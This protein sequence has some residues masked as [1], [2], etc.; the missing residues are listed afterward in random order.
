MSLLTA[1]GLLPLASCAGDSA[2]GG[3]PFPCTDPQPLLSENSGYLVCANGVTV[4]QG[5]ANCP[6][7]LPRVEAQASDPSGACQYDADC[8]EGDHGYC[9]SAPPATTLGYCAYGCTTDSDCSQGMICA[10]AVPVG[11]CVPTT[12]S[13]NADCGS[14]LHCASHGTIDGCDSAFACQQR[15][16]ACAT[17]ADCGGM[18]CIFDEARGVRVCSGGGCGA[19]GRP[20]LVQGTARVATSVT[21][22]D[23]L[24]G[25]QKP[26]LDGL[27]PELRRLLA[28]EWTR[29]AELEHASIAAFSRFL[30]ELLA[31]GAPSDLVTATIAAMDD[32][33]RHAEI[34]FALASEYSGTL[35]GP[36]RLD[37]EGA[38]EAK[39]LA[40]S[41]ATAVREGCLGETV[42]ALEAAELAAHVLDPVLRDVLEGIAADERRHSELAWSFVQWALSQDP[43]LADVLEHELWLV[44]QEIAQQPPPAGPREQELAAAGIVPEG[45]RGAV[46]R[47]GLRQIVERGLAGL[48]AHARQRGAA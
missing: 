26:A 35:V 17:D 4:R 47:A 36:G 10:C 7:S 44:R 3:N 28:R 9:T 40:R 32:E 45:L 30:L 6:S 43:T 39:T 13:S 23:W 19:I 31:F 11:R 8:T 20:F 48:I 24:A 18:S 22:S 15:G 29:A 34:C 41:V 16:D 42:A 25:G 2:D 46:R 33:R 14:G 21:R 12:C 27:S 1:L 37:V 5:P 38:L